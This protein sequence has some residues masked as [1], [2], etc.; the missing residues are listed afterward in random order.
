MGQPALRNIN[1]FF[2]KIRTLKRPYDTDFLINLDFTPN[3]N[4]SIPMY[5][6]YIIPNMDINADDSK[7]A[8]DYTF[9]PNFN[10][11][12]VSTIHNLRID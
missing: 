4:V 2:Y 1:I 5:K 8:F 9:T 11:W 10:F 6:F 7:L 3:F 12:G